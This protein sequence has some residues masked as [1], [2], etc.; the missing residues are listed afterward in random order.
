MDGIGSLAVKHV[1]DKY[2]DPYLL[3]ATLD[4]CPKKTAKDKLELYI[5]EVL[6]DKPS[7]TWQQQRNSTAGTLKVLH[8]ADAHVDLFYDIGSNDNCGLPFCCRNEFGPPNTTADAAGYWGS[9]AACDIPE[10][11]FTAFVD[12][13]ANEIKPDVII[14]TGDN[15]AHDIW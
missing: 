11:T 12:Q 2:L 9:V 13:V 3:C 8:L 15:I 1:L 6:K 5:E 4:V 14:W 10:H 7:G